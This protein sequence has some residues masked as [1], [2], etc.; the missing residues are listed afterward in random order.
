MARSTP[1]SAIAR[2]CA[3]LSWLFAI[4]GSL[5]ART[6]KPAIST[7][8]IRRASIATGKALPR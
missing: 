8:A 1:P 3:A 7:E 4:A 2:A 6:E 5:G